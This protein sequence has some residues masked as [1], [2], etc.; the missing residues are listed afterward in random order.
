LFLAAFT[1][2]LISDLRGGGSPPPDGRAW[3]GHV[4]I[5]MFATFM[6]GY[7]VG[8]WRVL[9][10]GLLIILAACI[11]SI[12]FVIQGNYGSL[13]FGIPQFVIGV[14]YVVLHRIDNRT[15]VA[16]DRQRSV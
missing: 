13:I 12:P 9:W 2:K 6:A 10:G 14:L 4:M 11:V 8:W 3:E 16:H 7:A 15:V 1:P 5:A